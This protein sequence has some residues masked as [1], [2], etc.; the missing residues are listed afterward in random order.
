MAE[1]KIS[2]VYLQPAFLICV[3]VLAVAAAGMSIAIKSFGVYL[4]KMPLA[5]KTPLDSL[6][7][8]A[9]APYRVVDRQKISG[10]DIIE[11]LGTTD[12]IQWILQDSQAAEDSGT[13]FCSLFIT[14]YEL[15]DRV[16]HVPEECYTGTGH[17]RL[18]SE[19]FV[20][21]I[22]VD[23]SGPTAYTRTIPVRYLVF[24]ATGSHWSSEKF[25]VSYLFNVNGFYADSREEARTALNRN[26]FG[27]YSYFSKVEWKFY[28]L[29]Y[30]RPFYPGKDEVIT[31][32]RKLLAAVLPELEAEHWPDWPVEDE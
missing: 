20:I 11:A 12:Y 4:K 19:A 10:Q 29:R 13:R 8:A 3:L 23:K 18:A 6:D 22:P 15:P 5:L 9:L 26:I 30:G 32:S 28:G 1:K 24:T 27:K 25:A 16:P 31:A 2:R 7:E 14:Y 17:Q 21:E